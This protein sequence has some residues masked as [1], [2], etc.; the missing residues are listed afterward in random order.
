[1]SDPPDDPHRVNPAEHRG[2]D[3]GILARLFRVARNRRH[4]DHRGPRPLDP[5][6]DIY[7]E[8]ER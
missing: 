1:M 5:P 7:R 2:R 8:R 3:V 4:D 6:P